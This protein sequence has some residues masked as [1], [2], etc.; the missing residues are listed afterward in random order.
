MTDKSKSMNAHF[1]NVL[2]PV[3]LHSKDDQAIEIAIQ[4]ADPRFCVI[5][6]LDVVKPNILSAV[7][8]L[9]ATT[10]GIS[11]IGPHRFLKD[12]LYMRQLKTTIER[13]LP[14]TVVK[15]HLGRS[16]HLQ[17]AIAWYAN[18]LSVQM[19]ILPEAEFKR[20][21]PTRGGMSPE[22]IAG[23][24]H[25]KVLAYNDGVLSIVEKGDPFIQCSPIGG[26]WERVTDMAGYFC[27][28]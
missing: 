5:H 17:D 14:N 27:D 3:N 24:T 18:H 4:M 20:K 26:R 25:C 13:S 15:I 22:Y 21:Y 9:V 28:N 2:V 6:L 10:Q 12:I 1:V 11:G 19:I 23:K 7:F 16:R 8:G